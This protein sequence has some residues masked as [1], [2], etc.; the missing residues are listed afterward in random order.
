MDLGL[1]GKV[2]V[3]TG[4][5]SGIGLAAV[6]QFLAEGARVAFCA[7]DAERLETVADGLKGEF[8]ADNVLGIAAS[9]LDAEAMRDFAARVRDHFGGADMLVNN[10][11][12]GRVSTFAGTDDDAWREELELKFFSQI[13]P[14]RA[15]QAMLKASG[16]GAIVG[17][18]S[19]LAYQPEPH[20][21]CTSAARAGV[22]NLLKSLA[23]ELAPDV[24][25]NSILLGIV[26]SGQWHRRFEAREDTSVSLEDWLKAEAAK[27]HI[28]LGRF[29]EPHEPANAIVFLA[30]PAASYITGARLEVSGGTSRFV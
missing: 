24:R 12:Q 23:T 6:R 3:V 11:G 28:P 5:S 7:R 20:M 26:V 10:A 21:V 22:Q 18:N 16:C 14:V 4:G 19:L 30:S 17:V 2:A 1:K 25:V 27:R 9:V 15:F 13:H 8:G 29:G